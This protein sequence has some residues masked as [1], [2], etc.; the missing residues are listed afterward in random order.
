MP[1]CSLPEAMYSSSIFSAGFKI[2]LF[3]FSL[4]FSASLQGLQLVLCHL[5]QKTAFLFFSA[6]ENTLPCFQG[7]LAHLLVAQ[8]NVTLYRTTSQE[9]FQKNLPSVPEGAEG[10]ILNCCMLTPKNLSNRK[11]NDKEIKSKPNSKNVKSN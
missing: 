3:L 10:I 8:Y 1:L 11:W 9:V 5:A 6:H 4:V 7:T 2:A